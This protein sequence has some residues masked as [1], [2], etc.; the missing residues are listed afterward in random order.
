MEKV[1]V[2]FVVPARKG[3]TRLPDKNIQTIG[4]DAL[5]VIAGR[6][7]HRAAFFLGGMLIESRVV[8][9]TDINGPDIQEYEYGYIHQHRRPHHLTRNEVTSEAVAL[10]VLESY[11]ADMV[12]L[13]QPTSPM[14]TPLD[15]V[16]CVMACPA[17][18]GC[19]KNRGDDLFP[20]GAVYTLFAEDLKR[21]KEFTDGK[22]IQMP[23]WRS[24]DIDVQRDLALCRSRMKE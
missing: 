6:C 3:S 1:D 10:D 9:T 12:C 20:N 19:R 2:L 5:W 21:G 24:V 13:V 7:A 16:R 11:P 8:L 18:T 17:Y 14:R 15:I 4:G 23:M 22:V